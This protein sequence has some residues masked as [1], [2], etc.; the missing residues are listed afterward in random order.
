MGPSTAN[1]IEVDDGSY[2][3]HRGDPTEHND[4]YWDWMGGWFEGTLTDTVQRAL[5]K[6]Q[7]KFTPLPEM[8]EQTKTNASRGM[9]A[10]LGAIAD[11]KTEIKPLRTDN[12]S[13]RDNNAA[14]LQSIHANALAIADLTARI[15]ITAT[16]V[17]NRPIASTPP[18]SSDEMGVDVATPATARNVVAGAAPGTTSAPSGGCKR[19]RGSVSGGLVSPPAIPRKLKTVRITSPPATLMHSRDEAA[20]GPPPPQT[21]ANGKGKEEQEARGH[22]AVQKQEREN[23]GRGDGWATWS[24][25]DTGVGPKEQ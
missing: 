23:G 9:G 5:N 18:P 19:R 16:P 14:M 4:A 13:L 8:C 1:P 17:S 10:I 2:A 25:D 21:S 20:D 24:V 6:L 7:P 12:D 3:V 22:P 15:A 11:L